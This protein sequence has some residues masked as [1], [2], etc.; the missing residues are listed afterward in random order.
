MKGRSPK[1]NRAIR[2]GVVLVAAAAAVEA[3]IEAG[4]RAWMAYRR[5]LWQMSQQVNEATGRIGRED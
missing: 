5:I 4:G 2:V 1:T 3:A